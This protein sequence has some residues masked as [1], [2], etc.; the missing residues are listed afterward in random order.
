MF[1]TFSIN[2]VITNH[3]E[4]FVGNVNDEPFDK[5]G[6]GNGFGDKFTVFVAVVVKSHGS[7]VVAVNAGC[8]DDGSPQISADVFDNV[9]MVVQR[10]LSVDVETILTVFVDESLD[11]FERF[12]DTL[13]HVVEKRGLEGFAEEMVVEIL[14]FTPDSAVSDPALGK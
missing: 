5:L 4:M 3:F 14:D 10:G 7:A 13:F 8:C 12:S 6:G 9:F 11:F 1:V 2:A